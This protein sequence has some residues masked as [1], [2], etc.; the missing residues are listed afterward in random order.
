MGESEGARLTAAL[1]M[2]LR[3]SLGFSRRPLLRHAS[4]CPCLGA[5]ESVLARQVAFAA[6]GDRD[7]A[8]MLALTYLPGFAAGEAIALSETLGLLLYRTIRRPADLRAL[9]RLPPDPASI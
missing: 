1:D 2:F 6:A 8:L 9:L 5:D 4:C 3:H 7:E